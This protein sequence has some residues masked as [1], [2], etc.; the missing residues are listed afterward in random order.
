MSFDKSCARAFTRALPLTSFSGVK[1]LDFLFAMTY[2]SKDSAPYKNP[3]NSGGSS[4]RP[5]RAMTSPSFS[6]YTIYG[7]IVTHVSLCH[8]G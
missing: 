8:N 7:I 4:R 1:L 5:M 2:F 3:V 6:I